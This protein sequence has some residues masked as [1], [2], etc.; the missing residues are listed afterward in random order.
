MGDRFCPRSYMKVKT[1]LAFLFNAFF[2]QM[3]STDSTI[4]VNLDTFY[5]AHFSNILHTKSDKN[6]RSIVYTI[7]NFRIKN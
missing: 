6:D 1:T 3:M 2:F 4:T 7:Y 5:A